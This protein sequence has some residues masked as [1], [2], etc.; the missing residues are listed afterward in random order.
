V[1]D[2]NGGVDAPFA[3]IRLDDIAAANPDSDGELILPVPVDAPPMP[4]M[5][6]ELGRPT[7]WWRYRDAAGTMLLAML[8]FDKADGSKEFLPLT[9]W[10]DPRG[11][12]SLEIGSSTA[13]ALWFGQAGQAA[14]R[15]GSDL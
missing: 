3:P 2:A 1:H 14:R 4:K 9:L 11:L 15:A 6:P 5:H 10:R 7:T 13:P 12:R 8:R